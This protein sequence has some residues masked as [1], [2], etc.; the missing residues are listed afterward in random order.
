MGILFALFGAFVLAGSVWSSFAHSK[1]HGWENII[2]VGLFGLGLVVI[3][4]GLCCE[5]KAA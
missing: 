4:I 2:F 3:G 5:K 1:P